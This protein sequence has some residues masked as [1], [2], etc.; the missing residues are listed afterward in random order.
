MNRHPTLSLAVSASVLVAAPLMA[1]VALASGQASPNAARRSPMQQAVLTRHGDPGVANCLSPTPYSL[2]LPGGT[3]C[4]TRGSDP[5][6]PNCLS[7]TP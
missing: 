1:A 3:L 7:P 2:G 6:V 5:G 4:Q